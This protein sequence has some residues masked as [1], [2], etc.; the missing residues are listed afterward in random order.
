MDNPVRLLY[1]RSIMGQSAFRKIAIA[2]CTLLV[3]GSLALPESRSSAA[4]DQPTS[5]CNSYL[6]CDFDTGEVIFANKP[7]ER[8]YP[9]SVTKMMTALI[10][11][12]TK[13]D[14]SEKVTVGSE[15]NGFGPEA[16]KMHIK[17]HEVISYK[18]LLYGM[19][20][21][22]G[23][24]AAAT[25]AVNIGG[26]ISGF[27]QL[28]NKKAAELGMTNSHFVNPHGLQSAEHYTTSADLAKLAIACLKNPTFAEVVRTPEY[29]VAPTNKTP[30]GYDLKT[31]NRLLSTDPKNES[32]HYDGAI[33]IKTGSTNAAQGCLVAAAKRN[34]RTLISVMLGDDSATGGDKYVKR[35]TDSIKFFNYGFSLVRVDL[36]PY[37]AKLSAV[38]SLSGNSKAALMAPTPA[39]LGMWTDQATAQAVAQPGAITVKVEYNCAF[40]VFA[41]SQSSIGTAVYSF[42]SQELFR[43]NLVLAA[44]GKAMQNTAS[45]SGGKGWLIVVLVIV[46]ILSLSFLLLIL[47]ARKKG[48][49]RR[50]KMGRRA[51]QKAM[52][53]DIQPHNKPVYD[54][55]R[56]RQGYPQQARRQ[57]DQFAQTRDAQE[58]SLNRTRPL[59]FPQHRQSSRQNANRNYEEHFDE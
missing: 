13:T 51:P 22:S 12:E 56:Q 4:P 38:G 52:R 28:M 7:N 44:P 17:Q 16:S 39:S 41:P 36:S 2:F 8:V 27:A 46:F 19:L 9:A 48:L 58:P 42:G 20:L 32:F 34:G 53:Q 54:T 11:L 26:S 37:L 23:N 25:I 57:R 10:L 49:R 47:Y 40:A 21:V 30:N 59:Q 6:L 45:A 3:V 18:D 35:W 31:T 50:S 14:L 24:D 1:T 15:V 55:M 5:T 29:T 43:T 33:G